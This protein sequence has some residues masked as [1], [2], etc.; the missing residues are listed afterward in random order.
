MSLPWKTLMWISREGQGVEKAGAVAVQ[1]HSRKCLYPFVIMEN[2]RQDPLI[3]SGRPTKSDLGDL[4]MGLDLYAGTFTRYYTRNWKTVVEAW[5]E[6]NGVDFKRTETEDEEKLSPEEVQEIVCAWRDE[7][8][9]VVTHENQLPETWEE[10]NDKAYY[11]DKPDWD[12]FGAMLLVTA[13][14]TYEETIPETLEKG[15]DFTEHPLIKR[16]AEDHEHV[17]SLFRSVMVWVPI[18]KSTMVFRG[19]M[20]TGNEVMIGTLGALDQELE[21]INEICWLAKEETI[22]SWTETEGYPAKTLKDVETGAEDGKKETY[23]TESLAKFAFSI[24]WRAMKFAKENRTPVLF[25][26]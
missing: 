17:Y 7:M 5:A 14:H 15:W 23:S 12:A 20:P 9:Q 6:A 19:P 24:F 25:D 16:L 22:L 3:Y 13:A 4:K 2:G 26:Y 10:S 1:A 18:T 11:T 8:L 21:H